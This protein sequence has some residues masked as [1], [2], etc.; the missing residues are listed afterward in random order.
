MRKD[1][2]G[3]KQLLQDTSRESAPCKV[4]SK[5]KGP[6]AQSKLGDC[7]RR[8]AGTQL[9]KGNLGVLRW[10]EWIIQVSADHS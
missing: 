9:R 4:N 7:E 2:N 3:E 1:P 6:G 8:C 5:C 10:G